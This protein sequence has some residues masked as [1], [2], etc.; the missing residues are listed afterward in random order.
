MDDVLASW[1]GKTRAR[2]WFQ[3]QKMRRSQS[4]HAWCC[5]RDARWSDRVTQGCQGMLQ[6][7]QIEEKSRVTITELARSTGN[8]TRIG[9]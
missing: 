7:L 9:V 4:E 3:N 8:M 5:P 6:E 1:I 2:R